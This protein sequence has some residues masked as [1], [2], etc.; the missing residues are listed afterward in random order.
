MINDYVIKLIE[1][2]PPNIK[3][4]KKCE[5]LDLVLDSGAFNG[6]YLVGG[7]YFLQE[8]ERL[9]YIKINR[10]S[11]C[12]IGSIVGF[13]YYIDRLDFMSTFYKIVAEDFKKTRNLKII[14]EIKEHLKDHIPED[15]CLRV[16]N[17][18]FITYNNITNGKKR[19]KSTYRDVDDIFD[20]IIKSC[21][22]PFLIDGNMIYKNKYIDGI[23]PYIFET[24]ESDKI[25]YF[26]LYGYDKFSHVFN[27][28]NEKTNCHRILAG[29]LD[30]HR[31]FI[32]QSSTQMCSYVNDW[33]IINKW[34]VYFKGIFE[35]IAVYLI[36][37]LDFV[38]N[39]TTSEFNNTIYYKL[40]SKIFQDI[41]ALL[42][43][44]F[45]L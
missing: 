2:L 39:Q 43:D 33:N 29:L 41:L 35:R 21:Y 26:D 42:L 31:F 19:I 13:L 7:L 30:I 14:T 12:S 9:K 28:K 18:L 38:R 44:E 27:I 34:V 23:T 36:F 20:S 22:I 15:V 8:M 1:N 24:T 11:G 17:K 10:I 40:S 3:D 25:L 16:N 6:S 32:K 4:A 37:W 5:T 45:C